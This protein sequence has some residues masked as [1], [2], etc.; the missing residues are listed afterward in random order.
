M[1]DPAAHTNAKNNARQVDALT[2][3]AKLASFDAITA[4]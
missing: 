3:T 2:R 4:P 1:V